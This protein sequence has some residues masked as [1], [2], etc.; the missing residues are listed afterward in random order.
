MNYIDLVKKILRNKELKKKILFVKQF[1]IGIFVCDFA[2]P[3]HKIVIECDGDYWH[4]NPK[5]YNRENINKTQKEKL[6][7]DSAKNK[8]LNKKGWI[9]LRF[10]E[11]DIKSNVLNCIDQIK[12]T[13]KFKTEELKK[14]KS[15]I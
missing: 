7:R 12:K 5:I 9:V 2:I 11:S 15:P 4:A 14:I 13:I 3:S 10:F 1:R 8:H 6:R